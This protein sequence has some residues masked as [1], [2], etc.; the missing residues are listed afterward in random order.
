MKISSISHLCSRKILQ[1][2]NNITQLLYLLVLMIIVNN[3]V[4]VP[5]LVVPICCYVRPTVLFT[6]ACFVA[7]A[8]VRQV[9]APG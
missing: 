2:V 3:T 6:Q 5:T 8:A 1:V 7:V 4:F 9:A